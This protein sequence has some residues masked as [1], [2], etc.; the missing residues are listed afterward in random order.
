M[1]PEEFEKGITQALALYDEGKPAPVIFGLFP[2]HKETLEEMFSMI[3]WMKAEQG[4]LLPPQKLLRETLDK[5]RFL[6][7][8]DDV[9]SGAET[10]SSSSLQNILPKKQE[11]KDFDIFNNAIFLWMTRMIRTIRAIFRYRPQMAW[12][13]VGGVFVFL[14]LMTRLWT[15]SGTATPNTPTTL[16][17]RNEIQVPSADSV[18]PANAK[19]Q[20]TT[21]SSLSARSPENPI[22]ALLV[23]SS[24]KEKNILA[25]ALGDGDV[26]EPAPVLIQ[27]IDTSYPSELAG[28]VCTNITSTADVYDKKISTHKALF[29]KSFEERK[30]SLENR[31]DDRYEA[32]K[33]ERVSRDK[34]FNTAFAS[35]SS[36]SLDTSVKA[37]VG[38]FETALADLQK[39]RGKKI[40][41][42]MATYRVG[43]D[44]TMKRRQDGVANALATFDTQIAKAFTDAIK[45]CKTNTTTA[46]D[47][48][49][50]SIFSARETLKKNIGTSDTLKP[51]LEG[52]ESAR[53][54]G[55]ENAH[56]DYVTGLESAIHSLPQL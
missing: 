50:K 34:G 11:A 19:A 55:V 16:A 2:K 31:R 46:K 22:L 41:A 27:S 32:L 12:G 30:A 49:Q 45:T 48:L 1:N 4:A 20:A 42:T 14:V 6:N 10:L 26:V 5:L 23:S 25:G 52:L 18:T 3:D 17:V 21:A 44:A 13:S 29:Q 37:Q 36:D 35:Y 54:K 47:G 40:D 38:K 53:A 39:N 24:E 43:I 28:N 15:G 51:V 8:A 56:G 9:R 33:A 7:E